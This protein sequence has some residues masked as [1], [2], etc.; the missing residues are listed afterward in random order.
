MRK[1]ERPGRKLML[2]SWDPM[3]NHGSNPGGGMAME[4][5]VLSFC[6]SLGRCPC[7]AA[8]RSWKPR[9]APHQSGASAH[10]GPCDCSHSVSQAAGPASW[11][12]NRL[13][14]RAGGG[15]PISHPHS[16]PA[17]C[18]VGCLSN[19]SSFRWLLSPQELDYCPA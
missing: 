15:S 19:N 12:F 10:R 3:R 1:K 2:P 17:A 11:H 9:Q 8:G 16:L 6:W 18:P 13:L 5:L 14:S 7:A 4:S